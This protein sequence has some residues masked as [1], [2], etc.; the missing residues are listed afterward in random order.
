MTHTSEIYA[1]LSTVLRDSFKEAG[2]GLGHT[3]YV[4]SIPVRLQ[5]V[6]YI[7]HTGDLVATDARVGSDGSSD[8]RPIV[9][10]LQFVR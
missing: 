4:G 5:R 1:I 7:W 3:L 6:D 10:T 9:A 8:H 2:W